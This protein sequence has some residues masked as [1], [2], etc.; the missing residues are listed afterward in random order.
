MLEVRTMIEQVVLDSKKKGDSQIIEIAAS[1][2]IDAMKILAVET[3]DGPVRSTVML[4][5]RLVIRIKLDEEVI[6]GHIQEAALR[7]SLHH[8]INRAVSDA[9]MEIE[10]LI[11]PFATF[12][13]KYV[14]KESTPVDKEE[15]LAQLR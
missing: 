12:E 3:Q 10:D 7:G 5:I 14:V 6:A 11:A 8:S 13:S 1:T 4:A 9:L 15:N 2:V